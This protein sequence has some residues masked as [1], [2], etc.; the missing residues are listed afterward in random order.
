MPSVR[1]VGTNSCPLPC[2]PPQVQPPVQEVG[3]SLVCFDEPFNQIRAALAA[4]REQTA[5]LVYTGVVSTVDTGSESGFVFILKKQY[6]TI[7]WRDVVYDESPPTR[8]EM[9]VSGCLRSRQPKQGMWVIEDGQPTGGSDR[10][11]ARRPFSWRST[12]GKR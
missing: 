1:V 9:P 12:A 7:C 6:N 5:R 8:S 2:P 4:A 11:A 10:R 3:L